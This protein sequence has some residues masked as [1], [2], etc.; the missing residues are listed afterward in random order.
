MK[1][2]SNGKITK[3]SFSVHRVY[4]EGKIFLFV[5]KEIKKKSW[6]HPTLKEEKKKTRVAK[7]VG[8]G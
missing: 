5:K 1:G 2:R 7:S 4:S 6:Y 3:V 8:R